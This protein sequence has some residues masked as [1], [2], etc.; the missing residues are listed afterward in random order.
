M[1]KLLFF[2]LLN[3]SI[4]SSYELIDKKVY[5]EKQLVQN[6]ESKSF[7][8][9]Q[10]EIGYDKENIYIKG[11]LIDKD[12]DISEKITVIS[13]NSKGI[14]Y[15]CDI[16]ID[17]KNIKEFENTADNLNYKVSK[18]IVDMIPRSIL[19]LHAIKLCKV[20]GVLR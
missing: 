9:L 16:I 6:A 1:K 18:K 8:I 3:I 4:F 7:K 20:Y 15:A 5:Y 14:F 2:I 19:T 17:D 13:Y 10:N 12:N 11:N